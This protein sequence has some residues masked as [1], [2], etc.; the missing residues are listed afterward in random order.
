MGQAGN[1]AGGQWEGLGAALIEA[2]NSSGR[3]KGPLSGVKVLDFSWLLPGPFCTMQLADL[4]ATVIKVEGP[5]GDYARDLLPGLFAVANRNKQGLA[6]DLK[7][8]GALDVV[9]RLV[10]RVDVVVESFRPG[11]AQRL[12][13]DYDRLSRINPRIVY[14]SISGFGAHGP[15]ATRPGHDINYLAAAGILSIPGQW[16]GAGVRGGLPIADLAA[17]M[18]ASLSIVASLYECRETGQGRN[19]SVAM[20]PVLL[21]WAQVRNADHLASGQSDWPH[22]S[23]LNDIYE[24]QDGKLVSLALVEAKFFEMF[25]ALAGCDDLVASREYRSFK[26]QRDVASGQHLRATLQSILKKRPLEDW[27]A[28]F[29]SQPIP[30]APVLTPAE[31]MQHDQLAA[32][33]LDAARFQGGE[34]IP[35]I[36]PFPVPGLTDLHLNP[37]PAKGEHSHQILRDFGFDGDEIERIRCKCVVP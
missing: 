3:T 30:F 15:E 2:A 23:P 17:A 26:E 8:P 12:G 24:T 21:N 36:F 7:A 4:G 29:A 35:G 19:L 22:L 13:I 11:V 9:D 28:L 37:A 31:A 20:L 33:G 32:N 6:L 5:G 1:G 18:Q 14:A 10:R 27:V 34:H 16:Q 25:C